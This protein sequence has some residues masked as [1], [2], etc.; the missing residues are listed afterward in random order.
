MPNV[1]DDIKVPPNRGYPNRFN[2]EA[3]VKV[4]KM[5]TVFGHGC[6]KYK[7]IRCCYSRDNIRMLTISKIS[8]QYIKSIRTACF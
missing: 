5:R 3:D 6:P 4:S 8:V 7:F 2:S 1:E